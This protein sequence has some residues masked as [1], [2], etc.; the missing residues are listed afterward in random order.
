M[1]AYRFDSRVLK[2]AEEISE[3]EREKK[4]TSSPLK[5]SAN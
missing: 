5:S 3:R 4:K 2:T 1:K